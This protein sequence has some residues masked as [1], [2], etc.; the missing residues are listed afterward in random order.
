MELYIDKEFLDNFYLDYNDKPIQ[1][2]VKKIFIEYGEKRVFVNYDAANF[3]KLENENEFFALISNI[4]PPTP[5][6][7]IKEH[8]FSKSDFRQTIVFSNYNEEWLKDIESKGALCFCFENFEE[9]IKNIIDQLHFRIDLSESFTDWNFLSKFHFLDFNT[10]T[11]S[12]RYILSDKDN[13]KIDDNLIPVL[14]SF[15]SNKKTEIKI[16]ILT[17][18]LNAISSSDNH[19]K[20]KA[21]KIINKL[22]RVF[23]NSKAKFNIIMND[24]PSHYVMHDRS[25]A[26]NFSLLECGKGFNLIPFKASDSEIRSET[27]FDKY[28]YNRLKNIQQKQKEYTRKLMSLNTMKFKMYP[29]N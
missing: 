5:V 17:K 23:A 7:S 26:T 8:L 19:K 1:E 16:D 2:I 15:F 21:K 29:K 22:N 24:F 4:I 13:Q 3:E 25:I 12:D 10:I 20:E 18:E 27:I 11:I 14:K 9:K 28:T 6:N